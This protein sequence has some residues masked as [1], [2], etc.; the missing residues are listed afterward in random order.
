MQISFYI[1]VL[2]IVG[3]ESNYPCA[4]LYL[5]VPILD[6][7]DVQILRRI[8]VKIMLHRENKLKPRCMLLEGTEVHLQ[9]L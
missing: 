6:D 8:K 2:S 7:A 3:T 5:N 9:I 1:I 4:G